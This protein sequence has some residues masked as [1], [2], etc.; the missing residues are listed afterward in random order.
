[1]IAAL[2]WTA[3]PLNV[4]QTY[5]GQGTFVERLNADDLVSA[6]AIIEPTFVSHSP[7]SVRDIVMMARRTFFGTA[8]IGAAAFAQDTLTKAPEE[9]GIALAIAGHLASL[10]RNRASLSGNEERLMREAAYWQEHLKMDARVAALAAAMVRESHSAI[11]EQA[12]AMHLSDVPWPEGAGLFFLRHDILAR[13]M[14]S[15]MKRMTAQDEKQN[16]FFNEMFQLFF[17]EQQ[18]VGAIVREA[19]QQQ[20]QRGRP[21]L[22]APTDFL[23]WPRIREA[24]SLLGSDFGGTAQVVERFKNSLTQTYGHLSQNAQG[25]WSVDT[26]L[27]SE[28]FGFINQAIEPLGYILTLEGAETQAGM[29]V[30]LLETHMHQIKERS[31]KPYNVLGNAVRVSHAV[32]LWSIRI[33][34]ASADRGAFVVPGQPQHIVLLP[35]SMKRMAKVVAAIRGARVGESTPA[36]GDVSHPVVKRIID[37]SFPNSEDAITDI[38]MSELTYH[39]VFHFWQVLQGYMNK[40][41]LN[42]F[43]RFF[44]DNVANDVVGE[45]GAHWGTKARSS[46]PYWHLLQWVMGLPEAGGL[47]GLNQLS[48]RMNDRLL[49]NMAKALRS[50]VKPIYQE[51]LDLYV[52]SERLLTKHQGF[53]LLEMFLDSN[54]HP[55]VIRSKSLIDYDFKFGP[56]LPE[57]VFNGLWIAPLGPLFARLRTHV[58]PQSPPFTLHLSRGS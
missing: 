1:M 17:F 6:Q 22:Q 33:R 24:M 44:P 28:S 8:A 54:I 38:L 3:A 14:L 12:K 7:S 11:L 9:E 47:T 40:E 31:K 4:I 13:Q 37:M 58:R 19:R 35:D 57:S 39:E 27:S 30:L 23:I 48:G 26:E 42:Y 41:L 53:Q 20:S 5:A 34:P 43:K 16:L 29:G 36:I 15:R 10:I 21:P 56:I 50:E 52:N 46:I 45:Y 2:F 55:R 25:R 51:Q 49:K 32:P 18:W